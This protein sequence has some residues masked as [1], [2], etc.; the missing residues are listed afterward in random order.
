MPAI[1]FLPSLLVGRRLY[2]PDI[3]GLGSQ[4]EVRE[5]TGW[6]DRK[7]EKA[8]LASQQREQLAAKVAESH[9]GGR[10]SGKPFLGCQVPGRSVRFSCPC[11]RAILWHAEPRGLVLFLNALNASLLEL[12]QL[13]NGKPKGFQGFIHNSVGINYR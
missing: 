11:F 9:L 7:F 8:A 3:S 6:V 4:G 2:R 12:G 13:R 10:R 5:A 1:A